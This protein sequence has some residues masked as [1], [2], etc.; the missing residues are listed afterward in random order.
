MEDDDAIN[1]QQFVEIMLKV[2]MSKFEVKMKL[3]FDMYDFDQDENVTKEDIRLVLSYIPF[4]N[5]P[6]EE[7]SPD[8]NKEKLKGQSPSKKEGLYDS[9]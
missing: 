4:K 6:V 9:S 8:K 3:T 1:Q 7:N 2:F 5:S